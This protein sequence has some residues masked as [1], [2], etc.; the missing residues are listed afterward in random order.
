MDKNFDDD[1]GYDKILIAYPFPDD[2][3]TIRLKY[4]V[5]GKTLDWEWIDETHWEAVIATVREMVGVG[6][7]EATEREVGETVS[8]WKEQKGHNLENDT[9]SRLQGSYFGKRRPRKRLKFNDGKRNN[10]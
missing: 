8:Q 10:D 7:P 1:S 3:E 2:D 4:Y 5:N 9:F 6:S